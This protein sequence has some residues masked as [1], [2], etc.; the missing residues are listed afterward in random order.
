MEVAT[1]SILPRNR[2]QIS[3]I[4][5]SHCVQDK[6][7]LY[8]VMLECK[9]T[10][11][12]NDAFVRDVKA[13]PSPQS[14]LFFDWQLHDMER[15]LTN[16]HRFGV[17]TVDT[18]FNLGEFYVTVVTYPHLML[19]DVRTGNHPT[20]VGPVLIHQ[21][22]DFAS[23]NYF[24][25][26]LVSSNKQLRN[27]LC[28]G[29]DGDKS[30]VEAFA[31][32]FPYA[33]QLRCFIHFK[34]NVQEKLRSL[35]FP[36]SVADEVLGDIFG[37]HTG[38]V[39]KEGLVD[40][41]TEEEFETKLQDLKKIWDEYEQP[42]SP[43]SGASFHTFFTRYQANVVKYHMRRDLREAAG[44]GSPPSVFTTNPSES[45]NAVI[46]K[47]VDYKQHQWPKFNEQLKQ[48]VEGQRDEIIRSL[49]G[50]GQY[51]LSAEFR[52]LLTTI[53]EWIK[54][55]PDQ[56]KKIIADF[57]SAS[58]KTDFRDRGAVTPKCGMRNCP[59]EMACTSMSISAEDSGIQTLPLVT[60]HGMWDKA[61]KLLSM[62]NGITA[63]PGEDKR[64]RMVSSF[65]G[66]TPHFV[67]S[68]S[69]GQFVCDP[70]CIQWNSANIC[71]HTLA[72]AE[73]NG[74]LEQFLQWYT[75]SGGTPNI[76]VLGME[77]LPKGRAG[78]KG[79]RAKRKRCR[80]NAQPEHLLTITQ[81][82]TSSGCGQNAVSIGESTTQVSGVN[83][84]A[85]TSGVNMGASTSQRSGV[86]IGASTSGVNIGAST[87]QINYNVM[88]P[89]SARGPPPLISVPVSPCTP[90]GASSAVCNPPNVN[91]FY[92]KFIKG[93][94][95]ICQGC[96]GSLKTSD[97]AVPSPPY[98]LTVARAEQRPFRDTSGNL[99]TPKRPTVYHYHCKPECI[100]AVEP[101]FISS[102]ICVPA[103]IRSKLCTAHIQHLVSHF[104][105]TLH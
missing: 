88:L 55:R 7:V 8:S 43:A 5:R 97:G 79:G 13:A 96:R 10:Q 21:Q 6:N 90:P 91:P 67:S 36:S 27:T 45:V 56:R 65:S 76:T 69:R 12:T 23:F 30:L 104:H 87:S 62:S 101:H 64:A 41:T 39:Y 52:Y 51:R 46:K 28:F 94:I 29:T 18:T 4:R 103:D 44:L 16:N 53:L 9:L 32:N 86:N 22:T 25:A 59:M 37:K 98:D 73:T 20:I 35:G 89:S 61:S 71:S 24:A 48:L 57:D 95:R 75:T 74:E 40:C 81:C 92:V 42:F 68:R 80:N 60:L 2:Q 78:Q 38:S 82:G 93:N 83:V 50:R 66:K 34:K 17:L 70:T 72:V 105:I 33:M 49:S 54:M 14:V 77:G 85:S 15:F 84:G 1:P 47:K 99:I 26:T 58:L 100:K 11:G 3:N 31:H 63:A 19:Q 102:S